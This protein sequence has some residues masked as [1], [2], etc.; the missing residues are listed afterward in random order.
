M[1]C[2]LDARTGELL[3]ALRGHGD[4]VYSVAFTPD[5]CGLVSGSKDETLKY[6]DI[7]HLA[8]GPGGR[9]NPRWASKRDMLNGEED[10][11]IRE[12]NSTCAMDFIGHQVRA[13]F[14]DRG[15]V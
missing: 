10:A 4:T 14:A 1:V 9:S 11:G 3:E 8:N 5:R 13:K 2:I 15:C 7:S 12:G 6:W